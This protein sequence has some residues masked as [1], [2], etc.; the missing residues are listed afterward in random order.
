MEPV[1]ASW[2]LIVRRIPSS[3]L[4]LCEYDDSKTKSKRQQD[5]QK[6]IVKKRENGGGC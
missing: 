1:P 3:I 6:R 2:I 4:E 5:M